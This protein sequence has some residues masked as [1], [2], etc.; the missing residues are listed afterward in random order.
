MA[1]TAAKKPRIRCYFH[2]SATMTESCPF[3][4]TSRVK[5]YVAAAIGGVPALS[6][7]LVTVLQS[8]LVETSQGSPYVAYVFGPAAVAIWLVWSWIIADQPEK[9]LKH[10]AAFGAAPLSTAALLFKQVV[11]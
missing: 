5:R 8:N 9:S 1:K 4:R 2:D 11:Q 7:I 10:Y 3:P 6:V